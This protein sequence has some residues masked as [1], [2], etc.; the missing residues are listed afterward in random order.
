MCLFCLQA[1]LIYYKKTKH[2]QIT[3]DVLLENVIPP[4]EK[5][6]AGPSGGVPG[7]TIAV[8][9]DSFMRVLPCRLSSGIRRGGGRL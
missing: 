9:C 1:N 7:G 8:G 4:Q 5:P 3:M 6:G 2:K